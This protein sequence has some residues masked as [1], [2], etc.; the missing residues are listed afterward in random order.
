[1][2]LIERFGWSSFFETRFLSFAPEG[3][4]PARILREEREWFLVVAPEG[5]AVAE[6]SGRLRHAARS[7]LDLPAVGDWVALEPPSNGGPA[8]IQA[9]LPRRNRIARKAAGYAANPQV[10]AANVDVL[11]VAMAL[12]GD[13]NIR[14]LERYAALGW[15]SEAPPLVVLTKSDACADVDLRVADARA[16]TGADVLAVSAV[17][18][19]GLPELAARLAP[20]RTHALAGM[21][22]VGKSTLVN[23]LTGRGVQAVREIRASDGRGR[24]TTTRRDLLLLPGGA[25]LVDTPGMRELALWDGPG[26]TAFFDIGALASRCRFRDCRHG[27]EPDCAVRSAVADGLLDPG[28]LLGHRKLLKEAA[29]LARREDAGLARAEKE[30]WKTLTREAKRQ[31]RSKR[32]PR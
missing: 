31:G 23:R 28:R 21:S 2:T 7:R 8:V 25:L 9:V 15:E 24:H 1:M 22:G 29:W 10:L 4:I 3:L 13:F 20:R 5:E 11:L 30:R 14:R 6:T 18:G 26:E 19:D 32:E 12:D 16:A 17:T 27:A